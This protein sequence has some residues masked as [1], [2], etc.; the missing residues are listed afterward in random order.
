MYLFLII[1]VVICLGGWIA[2]SIYRYTLEDRCTGTVI[3]HY[4]YGEWVAELDGRR[5]Q[6]RWDPVFEYKV[7]DT[8]Y[9]A[10]LEIMALTNRFEVDEVEVEYLPADPGICFIKGIRGKLRSKTKLEKDES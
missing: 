1:C 9:L 8:I 7:E 2:K 5:V 10:E 6:G 4:L 3:G